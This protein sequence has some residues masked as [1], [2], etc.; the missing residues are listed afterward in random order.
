MES[1][2]VGAPGVVLW[3]GGL[4]RYFMEDDGFS[5]REAPLKNVMD[6]KGKQITDKYS[7]LGGWLSFLFSVRMVILKM[8]MM[9]KVEC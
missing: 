3:S 4:S 7:Y 1:I 6:P 5:A 2:V 8:M 9:M